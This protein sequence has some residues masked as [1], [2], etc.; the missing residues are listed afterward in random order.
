MIETV[1]DVE[2]NVKLK[3]FDS[4]EM[5]IKRGRHRFKGG[6]EAVLE[7]YLHRKNSR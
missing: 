6:E 3:M 1:P 7:V 4:D 2:M 5:M